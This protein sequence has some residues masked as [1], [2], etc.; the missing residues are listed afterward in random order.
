MPIR[1]IKPK[2]WHSHPASLVVGDPPIVFE[3]PRKKNTSQVNAKKRRANPTRAEAELDMILNSLN[4]GAL[5]GRFVREWAFHDKWILDFYFDEVRLGIEVDG[6]IHNR[7]EQQAKDSLKELA[8]RYWSITLIRITNREVFGNRD[9]LV[10]IL[11]EGW[12][13]A[14]N[15]YSKSIYGRSNVTKE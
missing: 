12:K 6:S 9:R 14:K 10:S 5:Q 1:Y 2:I 4:N 15:N 3:R 8:C 11:R 7:Q 13:I